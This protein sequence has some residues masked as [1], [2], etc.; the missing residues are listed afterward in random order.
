LTKRLA[1]R[2]ILGVSVSLEE[3][4]FM[5]RKSFAVFIL[6]FIAAGVLVGSGT[7]SAPMSA[8]CT[9]QFFSS[10]AGSGAEGV[11]VGGFI[12][13]TAQELRRDFGQTIAVAGELPREN[14]GL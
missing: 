11:T 13:P 5:R 7:A 6:A 4:S 10:H 3:E 14:C 1:K 9:G 8:S 12:A 2:K